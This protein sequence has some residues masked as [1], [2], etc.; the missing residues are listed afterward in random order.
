MRSWYSTLHR[1]RRLES[2]VCILIP[3]TSEQL[4]IYEWATLTLTGGSKGQTA[5]GDAHPYL[6]LFDLPAFGLIGQTY[7]FSYRA[8]KIFNFLWLGFS[9]SCINFAEVNSDKINDSKFTEPRLS[10]GLGACWVSP[11]GERARA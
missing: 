4:R 8:V 2:I 6:A 9:L 11:R 1:E 10:S 5:L 7:G 3:L